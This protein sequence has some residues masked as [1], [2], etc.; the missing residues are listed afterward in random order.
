MHDS[1]K[2]FTGLTGTEGLE[3]GK[4]SSKEKRK[5][6]KKIENL[7]NNNIKGYTVKQ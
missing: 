7:L 4:K 5:E 6:L 3:V 2:M 1:S